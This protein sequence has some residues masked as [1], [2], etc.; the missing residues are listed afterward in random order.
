MQQFLIPGIS[1]VF[2][3]LL[4]TVDEYAKTPWPVLILGETGV[5]KELIARRLHQHSA[6]SAKAFLPINCG[7]LPPSLFESEL[8]G[9]ERGA[10]SGAMQSQKGLI[11]SAGGG[12]LFL[13]EIGEL[14]VG[15]QSKLLRWLDS[16]EVRAVGGTRLEQAPAR[17][18][19]ATHVDLPRSVA[20]GSF[21]LDLLERLGVLTLRVPALRERSE[22]I[23]PLAVSFLE[24]HGARYEST[25]LEMLTHAPWPGN[26]R[27]LRNVILRA[28][29]RG[30]GVLTRSLLAEILREESELSE[31]LQQS[32]RD[33]L[34]SPL[35]E[36]E[37]RVIINRINRCQGNKKRA[38]KELGIAKSTLHEKIRKWKGDLEDPY[39]PALLRG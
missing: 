21:R 2:R 10:F 15:L 31:L 20:H 25:D 5:G 30:R 6:V 37:K 24:Q 22:D 14:E 11:R 13:D 7:A 38:A 3:K 18:V 8:F 26:V 29:A 27:Q 16:G 17:L 9:Y 28:V 4:E 33:I 23:A 32:N 34:D 36:V 39:R 12:T 1:R 19:A 35:A